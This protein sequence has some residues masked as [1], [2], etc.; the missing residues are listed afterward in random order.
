[1]LL[2]EGKDAATDRAAFSG[3]VRH[4]ADTSAPHMQMESRQ[5]CSLLECSQP[6]YRSMTNVL[7]EGLP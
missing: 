5:L 4:A 2:S 7:P 3:K 1:M 6:D